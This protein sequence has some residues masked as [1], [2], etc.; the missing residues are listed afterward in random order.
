MSDWQQQCNEAEDKIRKLEE[1]AKDA[2]DIATEYRLHNVKLEKGNTEFNR[3]INH[4]I[5]QGSDASAFLMYWREGD[6]D[7]CEE[8]DFDCKSLR[9]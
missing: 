4:A 9:G 6:W 3:A 2:S 1:Y 7:A 5:N 8:Y